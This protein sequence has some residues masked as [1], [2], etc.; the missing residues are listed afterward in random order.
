LEEAAGVASQVYD[1]AFEGGLGFELDE[2]L[3]KPFRTS[4]RKLTQSN[5]ANV[6]WEHSRIRYGRG[7]QL[8]PR[9]LYGNA[10]FFC[11]PLY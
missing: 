9:D 11:G 7:F 6:T 8:S 10:S 3:P 1:E 5:V 2:F 4:S